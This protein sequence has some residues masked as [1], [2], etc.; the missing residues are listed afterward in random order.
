VE[1][2]VAIANLCDEPA[3][4]ARL[5][6]ELG[7]A[8]DADIALQFAEGQGDLPTPLREIHRALCAEGDDERIVAELRAFLVNG[9]GSTVG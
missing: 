4:A 6:T 3:I 7:L 8:P 1:R 9:M 5:R 2:I